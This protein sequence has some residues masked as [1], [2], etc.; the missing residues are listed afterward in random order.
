MASRKDGSIVLPGDRDASNPGAS[1][2]SAASYNPVTH[3]SPAPGGM[4]D[5][6]SPSLSGAGAALKGA[7]MKATGA[8]AI[9]DALK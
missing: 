9:T 4:T 3:D 7:I 5:H 8:S 2:N 6:T 1:V